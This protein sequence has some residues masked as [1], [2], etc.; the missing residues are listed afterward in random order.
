MRKF[1]S[2]SVQSGPISAKNIITMVLMC[3][4]YIECH[5]GPESKR[6]QRFACTVCE[7]GVVSR[8]RVLSCDDC[9]NWTHIKCSDYMTTVDYDQLVQ[10]D[11][12]RAT[13]TVRTGDSVDASECESD[14][15][16]KKGLHIMH[17]NARSL[18]IKLTDMQK[19]SASVIAV[20]ETLA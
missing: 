9:N 2:L 6:K 1:T 16:R 4:G 5:P 7:C 15:Q 13:G 19:T 10:Q 17:I 12:T 11:D 18:H 8:C 3:C 14:F 20:S